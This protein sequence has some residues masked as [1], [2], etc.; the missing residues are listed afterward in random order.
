M[1]CVQ[2]VS[3]TPMEQ[4]LRGGGMLQ[5]DPI[6]TINSG[7]FWPPWE[8]IPD[9]RLAKGC[10]QGSHRLCCRACIR[11]IQGLRNVSRYWYFKESALAN[12]R[13]LKGLYQTLTRLR[14]PPKQKETVPP[15]ACASAR[16]SGI[17]VCLRH[18][19]IPSATKA[20]LSTPVR[21]KY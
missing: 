1:P 9:R 18:P 4:R 12:T 16:R 17:K 2:A 20:R 14:L 7:Q 10:I 11:F 19:G 8:L 21:F 5:Q 6:R 13:I 3:H 15:C